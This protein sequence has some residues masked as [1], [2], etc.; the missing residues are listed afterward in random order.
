[1]KKPMGIYI[2]RSMVNNKYFIQ[3][4]KD[5]KG[6]M[7]S[8]LVKLHAGMYPNRELQKEWIEYGKDNFTVE[9]LEQL[10]YENDEAKTDYTQ[11]LELLQLIWEEK[12]AKE[13]MELYKKRI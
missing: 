3:A 5:L 1:M 6:V 4:T 11:D 8:T 12:L 7:N 10:E 13:N 9:I 2:I